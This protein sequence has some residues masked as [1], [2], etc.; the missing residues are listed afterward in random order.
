MVVTH[1]YEYII[2]GLLG[3]DPADLEGRSTMIVNGS[4]LRFEGPENRNGTNK[5]KYIP[6]FI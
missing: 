6:T 4:G 3:F 1:N 2:G 5:D